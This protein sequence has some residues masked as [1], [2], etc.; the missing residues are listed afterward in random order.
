MRRDRNWSTIFCTCAGSSANGTAPMG[1]PAERPPC[2]MR[3]PGSVLPAYFRDRYS[4]E[5]SG[6]SPVIISSPARSPRKSGKRRD[7]RTVE[8][9]DAATEKEPGPDTAVMTALRI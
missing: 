9:D 6:A 2:T 1:V 7:D 5:A 4:D 8:T 3:T